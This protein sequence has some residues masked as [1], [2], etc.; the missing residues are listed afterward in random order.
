[1]VIA[2]AK[3]NLHLHITG[4]AENGYHHL[5]SLVAF[6]DISDSISIIAANDYKLSL[7]G[8]FSDDLQIHSS[9]DDNLVTRATNLLSAHFGQNPYVHITLDKTIPLGA[10]L[11]GGSADAAAVLLS[12]RDFWNLPASD[13]LLHSLA[14]QMGSDIAACLHPHPIIMRDTGNVL[15]PAPKMPEL[16]A[17][18]VNPKTPC[19]TPQVYKTYA[20]SGAMFSDNI[21]FPDTFKTVGDMCKFLNTYTR[22][23][24]TDAAISTNPDIKRVLDALHQTSDALLIRLS[25]SG[26]TCFA[27]FDTQSAA[28]A[29]Q[30]QIQTKNPDWWVRVSILNAN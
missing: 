28:I 9:P 19:P 29:A 4:R 5:D 16:H 10:G 1:M 12:L 2:R 13:S 15:L 23:D 18:L 30:K 3:I 11:G 17:I 25:G 14:S 8:D 6:S 27:I 20:A 24:L 26:S 21:T 22:N 7:C